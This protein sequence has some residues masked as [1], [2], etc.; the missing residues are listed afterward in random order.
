MGCGVCEIVAK[1]SK[2]KSINQSINQ[3]LTQEGASLVYEGKHQYLEDSLTVC[4]FSKTSV[5]SSLRASDFPSHELLTRLNIPVISLPWKPQIQSEMVGY[6]KQSC[7]CHTNGHK[8]PDRWYC[9]TQGSGLNKKNKQTN[10]CPFSSPAACMHLLALERPAIEGAGRRTLS[11][12]NCVE[13]LVIGSYHLL[14][15]V[16]QEQW[17]KATIFK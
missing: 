14:L 2:K 6:P 7:H 4:L 9:S 11:Y 15:V 16:N 17:Q 10:K 12:S 1:K 13:L 3:S 5:V 8:F